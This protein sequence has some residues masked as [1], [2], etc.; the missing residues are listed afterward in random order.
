MPA[1]NI[2]TRLAFLIC[3]SIFQSEFCRDSKSFVVGHIFLRRYKDG[4]AKMNIK[5]LLTHYKFR[6]S[7]VPKKTFL[8]TE[9][10][11]VECK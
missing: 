5:K 1:E 2:L 9:E 6:F 10:N 3:G 11:L 4:R 8:E 7:Y